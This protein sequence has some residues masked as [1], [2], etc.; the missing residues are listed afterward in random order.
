MKTPFIIV[1]KVREKGVLGS[2]RVIKRKIV[3]KIMNV[4]NK[5]LMYKKLK[6]LIENYE[7]LLIQKRLNINE[8]IM[9][10]L[11]YIESMRINNTPYGQYRYSNSQNQPVLYASLYAVLTRHLCRDLDLTETQR[12]DW[13]CYIQSYQDDDGLF[14][15]PAVEN[16]IASNSDWWGWRHLTLHALMGLTALGA[17]PKKRLKFIEP[18]KDIDFTIKWLENRDWVI[19]PSTTSNQVQNYFTALQYARDF[20]GADWADKTLEVAYEWFNEKQDSKTGLWGVEFDTPIKLSQGVQTGYNIWLL[21]FYDKK[22]IQHIERIIDSC[23]ATQNKLGGFGVPFNSSACEDIDSIDPLARLLQITDYRK[24][25]IKQA[26]HRAIPWVLVNMNEDGGFVFR[27]DE[28]FVYGHYLMSSSRNE[29]AMFPTWFRIL[30]LA[31][32]AMA[33]PDFPLGKFDYEFIKC[34]GLQF[35]NI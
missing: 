25:N 13:I 24:E 3:T 21:Y 30:S 12:K 4:P 22:P 26:L 20:Q 1:K 27:R 2:A 32:L 5:I 19:D 34:P 35:W 31:Y 9:K 16:K 23:L 28:P 8:I 15:D 17:K 14:K 11:S 33:L 7:T 6:K 10:T 29:S 18:F